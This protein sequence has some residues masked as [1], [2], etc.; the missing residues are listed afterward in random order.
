MK[1]SLFRCLPQ[2]ALALA[3]GL[4]FLIPAQARFMK[5]DIVKIPVPRLI[6]NLQKQIETKPKDTTLR[7]NLARVHAM[8]YALKTDTAEVW[9]NKEKEG[10]W[11]GFT[12]KVVPFEA[13]ATMDPALQ[14]QAQEHLQKALELYQE[15]IKA[16]SAEQ[17]AAQLGHAWLIDK[18][19]KKMQAMKEYR[20][21]IDSA[22]EKESKLQLGHLGGNYITAEAAGYLISLLDKE[23]NKQEIQTLKDRMALLDKL[24][25]P[26]TPIAIP[27]QDGLDAGDLLNKNAR[28]SFDADGS[29]LPKTWTWINKNAAWLVHDPDGKKNITSGLQLFGNVTFWLMWDNGY[30]AMQ[31][32]DDNGDGFLSGQ[33]LDDLAL[34]HDVNGNGKSDPGEVKSLAAW[35]IVKLSCQV[36]IDTTGNSAAFSPQGVYFADGKVRPTFDLILQQ[37]R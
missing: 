10:A 21:V 3:L 24:P 1:L 18:S 26:I 5:P 34:W 37:Q 9:K 2:S 33:E 32:L 29:A 19:G 11:F 4:V 28:V 22:W 6:E 13:K 35:G 31:A 36:Q 8:A 14:K 15:V 20:E 16:K 23:Q 7:Y 17:L 30:Q 12:P 27:L 25:R